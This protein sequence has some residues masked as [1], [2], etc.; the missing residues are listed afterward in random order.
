MLLRKRGADS[1]RVKN[2]RAGAE[3][4]EAL[5]DVAKTSYYARHTP[6]YRALALHRIRKWSA[7]CGAV[8]MLGFG[9]WS[10]VGV[11]H[12]IAG[13]AEVGSVAW[14]LG[15]V[16]EPVLLAGVALIVLV[17]SALALAGARLSPWVWAIELGLLGLSVAANVKALPVDPSG[18]DYVMRMTGPV[19]CLLV[20][21]VMVAVE[22][23]VQKA[24]IE[25]SRQNERERRWDSVRT[26][27]ADTAVSVA[28]R[29]VGRLADRLSGAAADTRPDTVADAPV[30]SGRTVA[31]P[32]PDTTPRTLPSRPVYW[33][34]TPADIPAVTTGRESGRDGGQASDAADGHATDTGSD[35]STDASEAPVRTRYDEALDRARELG[36]DTV[37]TLSVRALATRIG[38]GKT[39]ATAVRNAILEEQSQD[40]DAL[41]DNGEAS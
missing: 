3:E 10:A 14:V 35:T 34:D 26:R 39:T 38:C 36:A 37:D 25:V 4:T 33:A 32:M 7:I 23:S 2:R 8:L 31:G 24:D 21:L 1:T 40:E 27:M 11:Q 12:A 29:G 30:D 41:S 19:G 13:T 22:R 28:D 6:A 5:A 20:S 9:A 15:W 17:R 16:L 18:S